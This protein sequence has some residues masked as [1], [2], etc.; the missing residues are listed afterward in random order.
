MREIKFRVW[1]KKGKTTYFPE[2]FVFNRDW[3]F[4]TNWSAWHDLSH[5]MNITQQGNGELMQ[6]TG[7]ED[8]NGKEI[9]EGDIVKVFEKYPVPSLIGERIEVIF[10]RGRFCLNVGTITEVLVPE[11]VEVIGN[12]YENSN[13]L[14]GTE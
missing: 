7:L 6:F 3:S 13:L 1:D 8:K 12:I 9:Y 2:S 5:E 4:A 14:E 10:N 11:L